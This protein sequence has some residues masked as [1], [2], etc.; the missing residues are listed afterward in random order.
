MS[1]TA[2]A[3]RQAGIAAAC[4]VLTALLLVPVI[5][6][7]TA[8]ESGGAKL[9]DRALA[10]MERTESYELTIIEKAPEYE[11]LFQGRVQEGGELCGILP[12]YDLEISFKEGLLLMKQGETQEWDRAE[13]LG[14]EGLTGFLE[15]PLELLQEQQSCFG[16]A[17]S[18]E[19]VSIGEAA[20]E[21]AYFSLS[22]PEK[23]VQR[24]FP[25]ID[26]TAVEEVIMGAAVAGDEIRQLRILV[27]F[28][29]AENEKIERCYYI[30]P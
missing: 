25:Q 28:C 26:C 14:L 30:E 10:G 5:L 7:L 9:M 21:T 3:K 23:T 19:A 1:R 24:L 27:E 22:K 13:K 12:D 8:K 16:G 18:G 2:R 11:L 4:I 17:I 6:G 29:G 20:C 15:T